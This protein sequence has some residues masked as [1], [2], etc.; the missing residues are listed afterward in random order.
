MN[1]S[2]VVFLRSPV[3]FE[4]SLRHLTRHVAVSTL[5]R[6]RTNFLVIKQKDHLDLGIVAELRVHFG[7]LN[8]RVKRDKR[9]AKVVEP[10]R[11]NK[12]LMQTPQSGR[13][14]VADIQFEIDD[15]LSVNFKVTCNHRGQGRKMFVI[16]LEL[17]IF[18]L[19]HIF[20]ENLID[21]C[22]GQ[23]RL[24][25]GLFVWVEL[26]SPVQMDSQIWNLE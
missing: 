14:H 1:C 15:A 5:G 16:Q 18:Q 3:V 7:V 20:A 26:F 2:V 4:N 13:L 11:R 22:H 25:M 9:A 12:L 19:G 6:G 21:N 8:Q 10:W 24:Q 17:V 23:D